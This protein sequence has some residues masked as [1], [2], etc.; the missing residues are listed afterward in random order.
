MRVRWT[1]AMLTFEG[2]NVHLLAVSGD[3]HGMVLHARTAANV[4]EHDNLDVLVLGVLCWLVFR[5]D[6]VAQAM[7][8]EGGEPEAIV[9]EKDKEAASNDGEDK[10]DH[11]ERH[12]GRMGRRGAS[13]GSSQSC[14][15]V[16]Q[17][18][19]ICCWRMQKLAFAGGEPLPYSRARRALRLVCVALDV[20]WVAGGSNRSRSIRPR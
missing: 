18:G 11:G 9:D 1:A 17:C 7:E 3:A 14:R 15:G 12:D 10:R 20:R 6:R 19:Q 4:A 5:R 13:I 8:D 2:D 16:R